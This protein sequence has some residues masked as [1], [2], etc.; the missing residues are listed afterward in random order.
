[1]KNLL[2]ILVL[3]FLSVLGANSQEDTVREGKGGKLQERMSDYIQKKLVVSKSEAEKFRPVFLR[4]MQEL[5]KT[6][7]E[8]KED[9]PV[10]QLRIA[11][12]RVRFRDE[13]KEILDETRANRVFIHQREFEKIVR[14]EIRHRRKKAA[15]F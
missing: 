15:S 2:T 6:H 10:L 4:Y 11:E 14:D 3:S 13:F 9:R 1:M 12:V 7:R 8:N 5:R